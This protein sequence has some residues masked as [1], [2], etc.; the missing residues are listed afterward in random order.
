MWRVM[1]SL[2]N[3]NEA[4]LLSDVP[5]RLLVV[6]WSSCSPCFSCHGVMCCTARV[7]PAQVHRIYWIVRPQ[8]LSTVFDKGSRCSNFNEPPER[9]RRRAC[10]PTDAELCGQVQSLDGTTWAAATCLLHLRFP[11]QWM[12]VS[13]FYSTHKSERIIRLCY[14]TSHHIQGG[15]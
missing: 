11:L 9:M 15:M 6:S 7:T 12:S 10:L 2:S 5:H 4:L 14:L 3:K 13:V 8:K 1:N